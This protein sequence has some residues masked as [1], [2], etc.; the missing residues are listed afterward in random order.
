LATNFTVSAPEGGSAMG[1]LLL[2]AA[3]TMGAMRLGKPG[4]A[5]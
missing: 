3:T 1:F 5:V 2:A 4:M